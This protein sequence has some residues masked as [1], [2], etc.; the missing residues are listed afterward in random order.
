MRKRRKLHYIFCECVDAE[1]EKGPGG[2]GSVVN[3]G[4]EDEHGGFESR[5]SVFA[6]SLEGGRSEDLGAG[7]DG[8][9]RC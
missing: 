9:T 3:R 7:Y 6:L 1:S 5:L 4:G 8:Y 2:E